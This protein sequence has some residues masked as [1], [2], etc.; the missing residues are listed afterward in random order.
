[1]FI[2]SPAFMSATPGPWELER[3][4]GSFADGEAEPEPADF[5]SLEAEE[6]EDEPDTDPELLY[7]HLADED[8]RGLAAEEIMAR[9]YQRLF[10]RDEAEAKER[11]TEMIAEKGEIPRSELDELGVEVVTW[12]DSEDPYRLV[13]DLVAEQGVGER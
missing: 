1:M 2:T 5:S 3:T 9:L 12:T 4:G 7:L 6:S 8:L 10:A 13:D 11:V